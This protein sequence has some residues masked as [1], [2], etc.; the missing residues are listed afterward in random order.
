[1][2]EL[3]TI[4]GGCFW[5]IEALYK[6]LKGVEKVASGYAG[7]HTVNPTY[8]KM[9]LEETGHAEV[10]QI[11]FDP[12]VISYREILEIFYAVHDPTTLNQQG[13]DVGEEY[14]SIILYQN[15]EQ[16]EVAEDV[17]KNF[18]SG[19]WDNPIVTE[20]KPLE[21]FYHAEDYHQNFFEKN[22][23]QAYCQ[24][25]INPKLTKFRQKFAARLKT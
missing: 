2:K 10:I 18:A 20:I 14:R 19:H 15:D 17:T 8:E 1:M 25:I 3:A 21:T 13:N 4:G 7:G 24:V 16:K 23:D 12:E 22:P 5:C 11:T 6:Q 9:H